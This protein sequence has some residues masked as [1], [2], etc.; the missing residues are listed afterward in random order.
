MVRLR[1]LLLPDSNGPDQRVLGEIGER[2]QV[3]LLVLQK[4]SGPAYSGAVR[5]SQRRPDFVLRTERPVDHLFW[6]DADRHK[7]KRPDGSPPSN[8]SMDRQCQLDNWES[9]GA[10][11]RQLGTQQQPRNLEPDFRVDVLSF[12][13]DEHPDTKSRDL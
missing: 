12:L 8:L 2:L 13:P 4:P 1:Q 7:P 11:R 10:F 3:L 6:H 5:A 9:P